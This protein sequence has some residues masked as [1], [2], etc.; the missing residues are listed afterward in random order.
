MR[1][2]FK[3]IFNNIYENKITYFLNSLILQLFILTFGMGI[4]NYIF[5]FLL[6]VS[7]LENLTQKDI[8]TILLNPISIFILVIYML[9]LAFLIFFEYS[10]LT[11]MIYGRMKKSIY[12]IR[13]IFKITIRSIKKL[14]GRDLLIFILYF[15]TLIP[16]TNL[17]FSL[18]VLKDLYIPRFITGELTKTNVGKIIYIVFMIVIFFINIRL[19]LTI[20]LNLLGNLGMAESIKKSW[21]I[22]REKSLQI[23]PVI[24]IFQVF[25]TLMS[26]GLYF[27]VLLIFTKIDPDGNSL[28]F[29]TL[30]YS[31]L[32]I[33][34]LFYEIISKLVIIATLVTVIVEKVNIDIDVNMLQNIERKKSKI[35][36][37]LIIVGM[38]VTVFFNALDI[39]TDVS[40]NKQLVIAHRGIVSQGVENSKEAI[41]A[42]AKAGVDYI[43][44]DV[45]LTKDNKFLVFHDFNLKRL[46]GLDKKVYNVVS[47]ELIE[48]KITQGEFESTISTLEEIVKIADEYNTKLLV[49]LKPHGHEPL[50]YIDLVIDE[51]KRLNID[52]NHITMSLDLK[53]MEEINKRNPEI[54]TGYVIPFQFGSFK[55][56][57]VDFFVI[58]D[59]SFSE[60]LLDSEKEVFVWTINDEKLMQKYLD[61]SVDGIITDYPEKIFD[62]KQERK[63]NNTYFDRII[64]KLS[65]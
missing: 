16:L 31:I 17:G 11:L 39:Y 29:Q 47:R 20:P 60:Y 51:F 9:F 25:L 2:N 45:I 41:I 53:L 55:N 32:Q 28:F 48:T 22:S 46:A 38:V 3:L 44:I 40:D 4:L 34:L 64:R 52:K 35:F 58:E 57:D 63:T 43:E 1:E 18:I 33:G 61:S 42:A 10:F 8:L 12:S 21:K 62:L 15:V 24:L 59:F 6:Y 50:N 7:N 36:F 27:L 54:K 23:F 65:I 19:F 56:V 5:K 30:S 14:V 13:E 26:L 49:E 37:P